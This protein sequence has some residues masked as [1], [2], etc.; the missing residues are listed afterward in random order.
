ML[1]RLAR[2]NEATPALELLALRQEIDIIL[3]G[4]PSVM[5]PSG[6]PRRGG[7]ATS[8]RLVLALCR[9]AKGVVVS[10]H[11]AKPLHLRTCLHNGETCE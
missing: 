2:V 3:F 1:S 4:L 9:Q 10:L 6:R 11:D 7:L 5:T 8:L